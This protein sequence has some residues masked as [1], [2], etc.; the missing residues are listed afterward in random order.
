MFRGANRITLDAKG[1]LAIP[2]RYRA[3]I[4]ERCANHLIVTVDRDYW[5]LIYPLPEW[6]D[7]ERRFE[8]LPALDRQARRLKRLMVGHA[9]E[10]ELDSH[11]RILLPKELREFAALDKQVML[12]GQGNKFE[13]WDEARWNERRDQWLAEE[14]ADE[15]SLAG[16]LETLTF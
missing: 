11:G 7:V 12:V 3:R 4:E 5:L 13:L 2:T 14:S 10:Q 15:T 6:E 16:E 9:S 1:R 8:R